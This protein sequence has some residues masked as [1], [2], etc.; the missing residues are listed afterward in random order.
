MH[1]IFEPAKILADQRRAERERSVERNGYEHGRI[2]KLS[3][4]HADEGANGERRSALGHVPHFQETPEVEVLA[5]EVGKPS[6][7]PD[8]PR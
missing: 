5:R 6:R 4:Q 1:F 7:E 2:E 8:A 3:H